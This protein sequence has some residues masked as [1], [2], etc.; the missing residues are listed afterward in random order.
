MAKNKKQEELITNIIKD[1]NA[2]CEMKRVVDYLN[3]KLD[4]IDCCFILPESS[5][6]RRFTPMSSENFNTAVILAGV[7]DEWFEFKKNEL[8]GN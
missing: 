2:V 1:A 6:Y 8:N 5:A 3:S 4:E 7:T